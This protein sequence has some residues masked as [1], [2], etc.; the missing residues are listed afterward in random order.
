MLEKMKIRSQSP[1]RTEPP[2]IRSR[3]P[4]HNNRKVTGSVQLSS[5][6]D[7]VN[8]NVND[9][10]FHVTKLR[11]QQM[12][13]S[14]N[15]RKSHQGTANSVSAFV[16]KYERLFYQSKF[17]DDES[18]NESSYTSGPQVKGFKARPPRRGNMFSRQIEELNIA[19][20][21]GAYQKCRTAIPAPKFWHP[22]QVLT[23]LRG[24][25]TI[26]KQVF[27]GQMPSFPI[28]SK[29][30]NSSEWMGATNASQSLQRH[31]NSNTRYI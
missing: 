6:R 21:E 29:R 8:V 31:Y 19:D 13:R 27:R 16:D 17:S 4:I 3:L 22:G 14:E 25:D 23:P 28:K 30:K 26:E 7:L 24:P 12:P 10:T 15:V 2:R 9:M 1:I 11:S 5:P 18:D 20:L